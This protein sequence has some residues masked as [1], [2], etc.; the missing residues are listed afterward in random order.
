MRAAVAGA[1]ACAASVACASGARDVV[2]ETHDVR[3]T[4]PA[5]AG[6]Y[7]YVARRPMGFV[8][9][10]SE[11]GL[12]LELASRAADHLADAL[13]ACATHLAGSGKLV[14]GAIR[15]EAS[16]APDGATTV[17]RLTVAPGDAVAANAL[18]CVVAPLKLT[19][20]PPAGSDAG[21]RGLA[22]DTSWG[23]RGGNDTGGK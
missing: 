3:V 22:I 13:D 9:V 15:V 2:P 17:S 16:V 8:A 1:L 19:T 14:D 11:A 12:G 21:P 20:F 5:G 18:L 23:P 10:A 7:R 6:A 4:D